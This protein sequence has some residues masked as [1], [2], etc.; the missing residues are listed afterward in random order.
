MSH[1]W[2]VL[3]IHNI[4][5]STKWRGQEECWIG[6]CSNACSQPDIQDQ[7]PESLPSP[8]SR[9]RWWMVMNWNDFEGYF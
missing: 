9:E 5:N 4:R 6:V 2:E 8:E 3:N 1:S 7:F